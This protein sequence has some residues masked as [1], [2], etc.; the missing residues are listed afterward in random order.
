M[1]IG[2]TGDIH[3]DLMFKRI[4]QARKQKYD[5][6]I[7]CGDFGY[8]WDGSKAE[9][10]RLDYLNKIGIKVLFID[11]NHEN[12]VL[13]NEYPVTKMYGGKVHIIRDNIIHLMR[14][15]YY[16]ID[17]KTFWCM[18][19]ANST[20]KEYRIEGKSWWENEVPT[21]EELLN[22]WANLSNNN[23]EVD[24]VLTHTCPT[25]C[26]RYIGKEF[27]EDELTRW[28]ESMIKIDLIYKQWYFGHMHTDY[29]IKDLECTCLYRDII[30][31]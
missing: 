27:R 18:G 5:M 31:I 4:F 14:G 17:G 10:K 12:H 7:I 11:G 8:I 23:H 24:F 13:L 22:G 9:Q 19:G 29:Y 15:E 26:L 2:I 20:D 30:K 25:S 3:G 16:N 1:K 28:F 21:K 6:L